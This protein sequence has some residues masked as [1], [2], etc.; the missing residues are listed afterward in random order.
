MGFKTAIVKDEIFLQHKTGDQHPESHQ[1]LEVVYDMLKDEDVAGT[2]EVLQPRPATQEELELN[3]SSDYI[4]QVAATAGRP[5]SSLDLDTTT[6]AKSWEA[7]QKA[8]GGFLVAIDKV[9]GGEVENGFALVRPPG[10]H[11]EKSKGMGFCLFN[12]IAIGAHYARQKYNLERVLIVDW[13]LHHGNGTQNAFSGDPHVLF[14]SSHQYPYYPGSGGIGEVGVGEGKGFTVNVPLPGGQGDEDYAAIYQG[15]LSPVAEEF[16]PQLILVSAGYDIY[17]NDPLGAMDVTPEG[18]AILTSLVMK[19]AQSCCQ[20]KLVVTLEGGYHL[21]GLRES[22]KT[23]LKE[24]TGNSVL[25]GAHGEKGLSG[26]TERIMEEVRK[27]QKDFWT[28]L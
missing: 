10:H 26:S 5:F 23:T 20:G 4:S 11:A 19:L 6:S 18:F 21:G 27:V 12:N 24:L 3:H 14:F 1:R 7:A 25:T 16:Q 13:D 22:V 28:A 9:M 2:F 8:A 15:L 17:C